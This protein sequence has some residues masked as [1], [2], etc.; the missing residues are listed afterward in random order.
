V[1]SESLVASQVGGAP[2]GFLAA[3]LALPGMLAVAALPA[4]SVWIRTR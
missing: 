2:V 4:L 1:F 3:R